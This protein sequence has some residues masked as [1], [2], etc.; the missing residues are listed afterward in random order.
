MRIIAAY[1]LALLGGN[2]NPDEICISKIL[3]SVGVNADKED[4]RKLIA[5]LHGKDVN[6]LIAAGRSKLEGTLS[7]GGSNTN[8]TKIPESILAP[9]PILKESV[10]ADIEVDVIEDDIGGLFD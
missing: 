4:V 9:P 2:S 3:D 10:D 8:T 5:Q 7:F 6:E 1:L